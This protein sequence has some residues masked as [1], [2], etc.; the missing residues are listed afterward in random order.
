[1]SSELLHV[2]PAEWFGC[3]WKPQ[4]LLERTRAH[5][6]AIPGDMPGNLF[7]NNPAL[8]PLREAYV[9][10]KFA[11]IRAQAR[12][13][14][15]RLIHPASEFPDFEIRVAEA[16]HQFEQTEAD[17]EGRT[18]GKEYREA[19]QRAAS[20]APAELRHYDPDEEMA[21]A[22]PAIS[23]ALDR[24]AKKHYRPKPH[25]LVYVNFPTDKGRPPL[26]DLQAV[27]L[28]EPYRASFLSI[29]LLWGDNAVRCWPDPAN[30]PLR[31]Q[32][33]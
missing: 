21:A 30:I 11:T 5:K 33:L 19:D 4:V 27:Q 15:V 3:W 20:G 23:A 24:K 32:Q 14:D 7:F 8:K 22:N 10:A 16:I 2:L 28:A 18:R 1:M 29:W 13:C 25:L 17:R 6:D 9:A 26:N 31:T 12:P